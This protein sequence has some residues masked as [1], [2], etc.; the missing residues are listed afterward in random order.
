MSPLFELL[1][2]APERLDLETEP[3]EATVANYFLTR[4]AERAWATFNRYLAERKGGVFWVGGPAG[5]GKTHF[6][7]YTLA[8]QE[9]AGS[10]AAHESRR[11]VCG[12]AIAGRQRAAEVESLAIGA[13]AERIGG[14]PD[15]LWRRL[16]GADALKVAL[17]EAARTGIREL[18]L[19]IDFGTSDPNAAADYFAILGAAAANFGDLKFTAI[20]AGRGSAPGRAELLECAPS[21]AIE[22]LSIAIR[23]ARTLTK[24]G[25]RR[26]ASAY[27]DIEMGGFASDAIFPFHPLAIEAIGKLVNRPVPIQALSEVVREA[28]AS[29]PAAGGLIFPS[30]LVANASIL[31]RIEARLGEAGRT[32]L[33]IAYAAADRFDGNERELARELI[34]TLALDYAA[35]G[36]R[37]LG[38]DELENRVAI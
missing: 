37:S 15:S 5:C 28:L 7:N 6:L 20:A 26:A 9:R 30:D 21:D 16:R 32:A 36:R 24:D 1:P 31:R 35:G 4:A 11:L 38:S 23:R 27:Q 34:G 17:Q 10:L 18:T 8:L 12:V 25:A 14:R 3:R 13:I 2:P 29:P 19:A 22:E 33:E